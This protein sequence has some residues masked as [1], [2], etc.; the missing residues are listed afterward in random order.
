MRVGGAQFTLRVRS[1]E[2]PGS[3]QRWQVD[4]LDYHAVGPTPQ[5]A[6]AR[7]ARFIDAEEKTRPLVYQ[8]F[9]RM[10]SEGSAGES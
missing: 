7:V 10:L 6:L 9:I 2:L 1:G 4:L 3:K 5:I 8:A